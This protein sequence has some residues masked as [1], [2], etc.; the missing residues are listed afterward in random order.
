MPFIAIIDDNAEQ[1]ETLMKIMNN[2]VKKYTDGISVVA[3]YPFKDIEKYMSFI[4]END[5][6]ALILD[7][8][9]NDQQTPEGT[10][11]EYQGHQLVSILRARLKNF[12]IFMVSNYIEAEELQ[13]KESEFEYMLTRTELTESDDGKKI[14][15]II[16]RAAQRYLDA[17]TKEL[18]EFDVLTREI[19]SGSNDPK[20]M[21][22]LR[23][24]Q[25]KL[26]LSSV[27]F[28]D[29]K[30]WLDQYSKH[31]QDLE[32]IKS[33]LEKRINGK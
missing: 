9:L 29:R 5:I 23:A 2:Y 17:N 14:V 10:T 8:K 24:L 7:E 11:V 3:Q 19:A 18:S 22:R 13:E 25:L 28:D 6:C 32:A 1:G 21:E 26:E 27:G 16:L 20:Q 33:E 4:T 15:P 31:I 30:A 12:P